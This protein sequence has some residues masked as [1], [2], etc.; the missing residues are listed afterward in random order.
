MIMY[1]TPNKLVCMLLASA[2]NIEDITEKENI[3]SFLSPDSGIIRDA[4]ARRLLIMASIS[5][6]L[7]DEYESFCMKY[8]EIPFTAMRGM[9]RYLSKIHDGDID[10]TIVWQTTQREIPRLIEQIS[11]TLRELR[12]EN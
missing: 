12:A 7:L 6:I 11:D 1:K 9:K 5:E 8:P 10:W 3:S 2:R 4:I